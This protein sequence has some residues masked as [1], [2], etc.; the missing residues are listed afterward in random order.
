MKDVVLIILLFCV[1]SSTL[2]AEEDVQ[3]VERYAGVDE[4]SG[5]RVGFTYLSPGFLSTRIATDVISQYGW[6]FETKFASRKGTK[7]LIEWVFLAG[8]ME[9][10]LFLPSISSL[11]GMRNDEGYE[12]AFGPNLSL[13]GISYVLAVGKN[14]NH[15][16]LNIP[17]NLSW[18]PSHDRSGHRF[19]L[20]AGF[21]FK[22]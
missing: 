2:H 4:L 19:S 6:Q 13:S 22:K 20:T 14:F 9:Q 7:A 16:D 17:V 10:G 21:N 1:F 18:V 5:P 12:F 8:G 15:E 11:V 3:S